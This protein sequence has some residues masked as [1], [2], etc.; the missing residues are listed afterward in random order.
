MLR[1][2]GEAKF[3]V[4]QSTHQASLTMGRKYVSRSLANDGLTPGSPKVERL[5]RAQD[6]HS[7]SLQSTVVVSP[8]EILGLVLMS[9]FPIWVQVR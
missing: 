9:G 8:L 7:P 6:Y 2:W 5:P 1:G 4:V 3:K